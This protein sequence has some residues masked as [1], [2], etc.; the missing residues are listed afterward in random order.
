[1]L[2]GKETTEKTTDEH[3]NRNPKWRLEDRGQGGYRS[4]PATFRG[5]S[6]F[7]V[8]RRAK[9]DK[10]LLHSMCRE[11][12]MQINHDSSCQQL[13]EKGNLLFQF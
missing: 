5:Q 10:A 11:L 6:T 13:L 7:S 2:T 9:R 1:M 12:G 3:G 4:T 8:Q